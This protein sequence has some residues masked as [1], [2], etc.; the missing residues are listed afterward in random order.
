[1]R[2]WHRW[3]P[4]ALALVVVGAARGGSLSVENVPEGSELRHP[5]VLLRGTVADRALRR[6][7]VANAAAGPPMAPLEGVAV[8]GRFHALA[9]LRPGG[10]QVTVTAGPERV[11]LRL[12]YVPQTNPVVTRIF[13]M[14]D[15]SG[16]TDID[17]PGIAQD[18]DFTGRL[19]TALELYQALVADQM[20]ACGHGWQTFNIDRDEQGR[21]RVNVIRGRS[22]AADYDRPGYDL[23]AEMDRCI[24]EQHPRQD[25]HELALAAFTHHDAWRPAPTRGRLAVTCG[26]ISG[27]VANLFFAWPRNEAEVFEKLMD[28][29]LLDTPALAQHPEGHSLGEEVGGAMGVA[30]HELA[31]NWGLGHTSAS[32]EIVNGGTLTGFFAPQ[33]PARRGEAGPQSVP[34]DSGTRIRP[35]S[36]AMLSFARAFALDDRPEVPGAP[37][38]IALDR[39]SGD[40]VVSSSTGV[41]VVALFEDGV[42]RAASHG[43]HRELAP[44]V[45]VSL[46]A[47]AT[48][49]LLEKTLVM[50]VDGQGRRHQLDLKRLQRA[51][52]AWAS[53]LEHLERAVFVRGWRI[54]PRVRPWP[55]DRTFPPLTEAERASIETATLAVPPI[56]EPANPASIEPAGLLPNEPHDG[57]AAYL[58]TTFASPAPQDL[59]FSTGSD[60]SL[61]IW[62]DGTLVHS[63]LTR[64]GQRRGQEIGR[65]TV[66]AG[67]HR[68][69]LEVANGG[70]PW[71]VS[72]ALLDRDGE[73]LVISDRGALEPWRRAVGLTPPP[74]P[75][76]RW[77]LR[78]IEP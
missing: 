47:A 55:D 76:T 26:R 42:L 10:N 73:P 75:R 65:A 60:D 30:L 35:Q 38:R 11:E 32:N 27:S 36:A 39:A 48:Q 59:Q 29:R 51:G 77:P 5:L 72:L 49:C 54:H 57:V 62:I 37:P 31:H 9:R 67:E 61:R 71:A 17:W 43:G 46:G 15:A 52:Q 56:P 50:G 2:G 23:L 6:V 16:R 63:V 74:G 28:P 45:R 70:G 44:A 7:T 4:V 66:A 20:H 41:A 34:F 13:W 21:P 14:T 1:M 8:D 18:H 24:R 78:P 40:L 19:A 22:A 69:L 53:K 58:A 25:S 64:R 12:T 3:L 33:R 68:L